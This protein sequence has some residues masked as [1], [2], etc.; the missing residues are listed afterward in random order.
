MTYIV[1]LPEML[2][3]YDSEVLIQAEMGSGRIEDGL[4]GKVRQ[5][6]KRLHC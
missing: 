3:E 1:Y 5:T 6:S 2:G 4:I